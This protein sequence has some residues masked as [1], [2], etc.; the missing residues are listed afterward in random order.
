MSTTRVHVM[1]SVEM[2]HDIEDILWDLAGKER[3]RLTRGG[4]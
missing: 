3:E 2:T 4:A 1:L